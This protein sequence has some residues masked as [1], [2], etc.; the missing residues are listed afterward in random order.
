MHTSHHLSMCINS[1]PHPTHPC[2]ISIPPLSLQLSTQIF[3]VL[4]FHMGQDFDK[5][6]ERSHSPSVLRANDEYFK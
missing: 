1:S 2:S 6:S 3:H 5:T 4:K